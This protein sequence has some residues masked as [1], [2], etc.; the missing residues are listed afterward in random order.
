MPGETSLPE[1]MVLGALGGMGA[2]TCCH[3]LD[4]VRVQMQ[5]DG[6]SGGAKQYN[7]FGDAVAK[8][9]QR[10]GIIGG[11]YTGI[12]AAYL[13]QWTYGSCRVGIYAWLLA[14]VN[15]TQEQGV[16]VPF[17]KKLLMGST[18]GAI[19]SAFG[20]PSEVALVRMGADAK[21]PP[22]LRRNYK[23]V[24]DCLV[25]I[26]KEEGPSKLFA[27]GTPT[28]IRATLLSSAVLGCYSEAK[29]RLHVMFPAVFGNKEGIPLMFT[30]TMCASFVA[31]TV[32]NPFDVVKS[33]VQNMP[34]PEPGQ[35]PMYTSM[36]DCFAKSVKGE[37]PFIL[38]RGFTPAFL[39]LA[40]Y[41][42][43]SLILT[44]KLTKAWTGKAGL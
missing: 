12:D 6:G 13:R 34:K 38:M 29:E 19:G 25:R 1:R 33:R 2:A 24:V 22:E 14:Y 5:V 11:L 28:I 44:D 16:P 42:T 8:I 17:W 41:T 9:V 31:N 40:P 7:G 21:S 18:S 20:L 30:S 43:I 32:S 35:P 37:G 3:P 39:K 10:K 15:K 27:G 4:V 23:N 26:Y 36:V